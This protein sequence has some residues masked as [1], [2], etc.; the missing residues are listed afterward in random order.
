MMRLAV[1]EAMLGDELIAVQDFEA[2]HRSIG[3][4]GEAA[5][6]IGAAFLPAQALREF[7]PLQL[8][9]GG[10]DEAVV[11]DRALFGER[12]EHGR[13]AQDVDET[14]DAARVA[15]H[16]VAGGRLEDRAAIRPGDIQAD[17]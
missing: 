8:L 2:R 11:D 7:N 14:W 10:F 5:G 6:A 9:D 17:A 15:E 4:I 3:R 12:A 16:D 1:S 13:V